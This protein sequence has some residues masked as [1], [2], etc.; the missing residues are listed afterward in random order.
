MKERKT[1]LPYDFLYDGID[2]EKA[3]GDRGTRLLIPRFF[4]FGRQ[5]RSE[6]ENRKRKQI[7]QAFEE[8]KDSLLYNHP[9]IVCAVPFRNQLLLTIIDGHHRYRDSGR[10]AIHIMPSIVSTSEVIVEIINSYKSPQ[11][12]VDLTKFKEDLT[13]HSFEASG[14]LPQNKQSRMIPGISSIEELK[15]KFKS[16]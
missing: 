12:Q 11:N 16:F 9:I 2:M 15:K 3:I 13:F 1:L 4:I 5:N 6:Y 14:M 8:E 10:F 7:I